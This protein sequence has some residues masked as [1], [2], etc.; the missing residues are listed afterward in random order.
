MFRFPLVLGDIRTHYTLIHV[1]DRDYQLAKG[2]SWLL[3]NLL[4]KEYSSININF[5]K[6]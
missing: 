2:T 4:S 6:S 5:F 3:K 1:W